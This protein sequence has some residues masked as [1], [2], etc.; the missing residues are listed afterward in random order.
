[1]GGAV[2]AVRECHRPVQPPVVVVFAVLAGASGTRR[3]R[4]SRDTSRTSRET[5]SSCQGPPNSTHSGRICSSLN[6]LDLIFIHSNI[7]EKN[8]C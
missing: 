2:C 8:Y 4:M 1:M 3:G 6:I 5:S 7:H